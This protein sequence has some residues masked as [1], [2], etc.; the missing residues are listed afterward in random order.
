MNAFKLTA[1]TLFFASAFPIFSQTTSKGVLKTEA[2]EA[3]VE[4]AA[5]PFSF[6]P[7]SI[8]I[9]DGI[10]TETTD[11]YTKLK[12]SELSTMSIITD[13]TQ[14]KQFTKQGEK[15]MCVYLI[16]TN[17]VKAK[18]VVNNSVTAKGVKQ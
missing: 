9:I 16:T 5:K 11:D 1:V 3:K 13:P 15:I 6:M 12:T 17:K 2:K 14:L 8:Y 4:A 10:R 7:K 18:P